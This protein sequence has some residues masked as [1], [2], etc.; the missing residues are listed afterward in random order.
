LAG[1]LIER[2]LAA[3]FEDW[4]HWL[5]CNRALAVPCER[6]G[7]PTPYTRS[8]ARAA[9]WQWRIPLQHRTGNGYVYCSQFISDDEAASVLLGNLDGKALA[10]PRP[11]RFTPGRRKQAWSKNVV[12]VG[13]SAGFLEPLE[14]TSIHL[15]Q[16]AIAKLLSLFPTRDCDSC[17]VEQFNRVMLQEYEGV[18]DFL[19][20]HYHSTASK[21]EPLWQYCRNMPLPDGLKYKEEHF[22]RTGRIVIAPEELFR[23]ASWLAVLMGQG[24][25]PTD[26]NPLLDSISSQDNRGYL[27]HVK[28]VLRSACARLPSHESHLQSVIAGARREAP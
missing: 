8:T 23:D 1:I 7:A 20:L 26:Y 21:P 4:S 17:T 18:R 3:G 19:V 28:D 27:R 5:P 2:V 15:I 13:L 24:Q 12:A 16:S 10:E 25:M 14:S 11:I 6:A 22:R 9:G